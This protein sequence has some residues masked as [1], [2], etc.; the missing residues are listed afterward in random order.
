MKR[1]FRHLWK[2]M[3]AAMKSAHVQLRIREDKTRTPAAS[4]S[5]RNDPSKLINRKESM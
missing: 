4:A 1:R 5:A 3:K 2:R